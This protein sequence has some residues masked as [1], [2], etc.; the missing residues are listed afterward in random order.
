MSVATAKTP[1]E[2]SPPT[3]TFAE[4][5]PVEKSKRMTKPSGYIKPPYR[6]CLYSFSKTFDNRNALKT[7]VDPRNELKITRVQ[8]DVSGTL[9]EIIN[10]INVVPRESCSPH[11]ELYIPLMFSWGAMITKF[12]SSSW[13]KQNMA[14]VLV[15]ISGGRFKLVTV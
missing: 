11:E 10:Y 9:K 3:P 8:T 13:W 1:M 12:M 7:P 15:E 6:C 4:N 2:H 14:L 5:P